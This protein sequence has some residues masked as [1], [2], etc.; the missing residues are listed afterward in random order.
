MASSACGSYFK[1]ALPDAP[2]IALVGIYLRKMK[3]SSHETYTNVSSRFTTVPDVCTS[4]QPDSLA[5]PEPHSNAKGSPVDTGPDRPQRS[6]LA[7]GDRSCQEFM[8]AQSGC[9]FERPSGRIHASLEA[10]GTLQCAI[11]VL[12]PPRSLAVISTGR[13]D[14][15]KGLTWKPELPIHPPASHIETSMLVV[16]LY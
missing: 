3:T 12:M 16:G 8:R 6:T 9:W 1:Q 15:Y 5:I 14:E 11:S 10:F 2:V 7:R 4:K 13:S